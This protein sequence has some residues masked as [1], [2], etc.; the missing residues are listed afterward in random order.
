MSLAIQPTGV[1]PEMAQPLSGTHEHIRIRIISSGW[2]PVFRC[3]K[4]GMTWGEK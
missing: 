1:I 4:T 2:V 3:A